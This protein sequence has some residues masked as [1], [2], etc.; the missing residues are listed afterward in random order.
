MASQT[1]NPLV[2]PPDDL[3][4]VLVKVQD[5][6]HRNPEFQLPNNP[7][8]DIWAWYAIRRVTLVVMEDFLL[9]ILSIPLIDKS[10]KMKLYKVHNLPAL[11]PKPNLQYKY[12]IEDEYL[13]VS[14]WV[15]MHL[16]P[17]SMMYIF[18]KWHKAVYAC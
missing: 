6:M 18:V 3:W 2:L 12:V 9:L 8:K 10:L 1:L 17:M 11:K 16:Y 5:E 14:D 7:D 15:S 13:A 4:D